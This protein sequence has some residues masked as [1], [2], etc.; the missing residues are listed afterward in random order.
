[1]Q[2][3]HYLCRMKHLILI[4]L[5][6]VLLS[7]CNVSRTITTTAESYVKGDTAVNVQTRTTEVYHGKILRY[8]ER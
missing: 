8:Y 2:A 1:M 4:A 3:V 6:A 7:A 5:L